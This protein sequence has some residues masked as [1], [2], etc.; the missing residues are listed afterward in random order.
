VGMVACLRLSLAADGDEAA[1]VQTPLTLF[2]KT[3]HSRLPSPW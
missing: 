2:L 1:F 3:A